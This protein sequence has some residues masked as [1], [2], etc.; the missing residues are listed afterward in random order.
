MVCWSKILDGRTLEN[1]S[2]SIMRVLPAEAV[3]GYAT[4]RF[5]KWCH[6]LQPSIRLK[7]VQIGFYSTDSNGQGIDRMR[8]E[9]RILVC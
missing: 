9:P 8:N 7:R 3:Q 1:D 5:S 2:A 4:P 6:L